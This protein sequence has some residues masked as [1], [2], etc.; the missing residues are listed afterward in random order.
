M[1]P[2]IQIFIFVNYISFRKSNQLSVWPWQ[3]FFC[4]DCT[5]RL[6]YPVFALTALLIAKSETV[7]EKETLSLSL[8]ALL[9]LPLPL[10]TSLF[11]LQTNHPLPRDS[12]KR[13]SQA[14]SLIS[15]HFLALIYSLVLVLIKIKLTQQLF[16]SRSWDQIFLIFFKE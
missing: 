2:T 11:C 14:T 4:F 13:V 3:F 7:R 10:P 6:A 12:G 9:L 16:G 5:P 15:L 1:G 8:S